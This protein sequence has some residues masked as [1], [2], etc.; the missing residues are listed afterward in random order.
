MIRENDSYSIIKIVSSQE[1]HLHLKPK[2]THDWS[3]SYQGH[4]KVCTYVY[5]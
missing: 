1:F 4:N 3:V 2:E 5:D